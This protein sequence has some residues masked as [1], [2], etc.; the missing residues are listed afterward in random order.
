MTSDLPAPLLAAD[1]DVRDLD[2]FMLNVERLMA[3]ELVALSSHE[4]IAAAL[5]LWCRAWK[6]LPAASLPD[7]DR[8]IAAFA[9][10]P[11]PKF[12]KIKPEIL[13][14]F[15]KCSDGR[16]YHKVLV[17][18]AVSA[19][20]RKKA[21]HGRRERDAE[22]LRQWRLKQPRNAD[23]THDETPDETR[24]VRE[25]QG[26]GRDRDLKKKE[27]DAAS[28]T[29]DAAIPS[30]DDPPSQSAAVV[31]TPDADL[32]RRGR[33]VLGPTAGGMVKRLLKAQG[34]NIALARA[35]I[36][37]ASA[38]S[39]PREYVGAIIGRSSGGRSDRDLGGVRSSRDM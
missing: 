2:G 23:E 20:G 19:F 35:A 21:F 17:G 31:S 32:Y 22:R 30:Q 18:E 27:E 10:L 36:E 12:R 7:D 37:T 14:G 4:V 3:S 34:E 9:R 26:Q 39:D 25:G 33:E 6:Q 15:I 38:K 5:F 24:F 13:R 11:L 28:L 29:S 1:V 16:L 8:V